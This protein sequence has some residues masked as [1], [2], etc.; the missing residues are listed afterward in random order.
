MHV[1]VLS[2]TRA[3]MG[4]KAFVRFI[5]KSMQGGCLCSDLVILKLHILLSINYYTLII[6]H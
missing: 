4:R 1:R 3:V 5:S 6:A 2:L